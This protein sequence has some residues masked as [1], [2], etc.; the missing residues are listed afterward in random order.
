MQQFGNDQQFGPL[1]IA[2][3]LKNQESDSADPLGVGVIGWI[4]AAVTAL[5]IFATWG[6]HHRTSAADR[7][8]RR[9]REDKRSRSID[10]DHL[11][12]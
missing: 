3:R 7:A 8:I 6:W 10:L 9:R 5:A 4:A 1:L 11:S 12:S 2:A